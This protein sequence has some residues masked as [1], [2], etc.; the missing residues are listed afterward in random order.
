LRYHSISQQHVETLFLRDDID[1]YCV[2][3][4]LDRY[5]EES[6]RRSIYDK[7][8]LRQRYLNILDFIHAE[9]LASGESEFC[10]FPI[11]SKW[12]ELIIRSLSI[13]SAFSGIAST[14]IPEFINCHVISLSFSLS[15]SITFLAPLVITLPYFVKKALD[16][17]SK[18]ERV[19]RTQEVLLSA[20]RLVIQEMLNKKLLEPLTKEQTAQLAVVPQ[21]TRPPYNS[22]LLNSIYVATTI[23][24]L[25]FGM[26]TTFSLSTPVGWGIVGLLTLCAGVGFFIYHNYHK[27]NLSHKQNE[28]VRLGS[29]LAF[30]SHQRSPEAKKIEQLEKQNK[31]FQQRNTQLERENRAHQKEIERLHYEN[32]RLTLRT[33]HLSEANSDTGIP[34][35]PMENSWRF[36]LL[37]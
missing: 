26:L 27:K 29:E 10:Q 4:K 1:Y 16:D 14:L 5:L 30:F 13:Y 19:L 36:L 32:A 9:I 11:S 31:A 2:L 15:L 18:E 7:K 17:M 6:N 8:A 35:L 23:F 20:K 34:H 37:T 22:T 3:E 24:A 21:Q 33:S 28:L 12:P 25:G